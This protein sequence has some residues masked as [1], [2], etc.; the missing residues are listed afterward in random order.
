[1]EPHLAIPRRPLS[2]FAICG[3][4][5]GSQRL[6][7]ESA[8]PGSAPESG[9]TSLARTASPRGWDSQS[10]IASDL[11]QAARAAWASPWAVRA[12]P[13]QFS[14]CASPALHLSEAWENGMHTE[15]GH[16]TAVTPERGSATR[17]TIR[18]VMTIDETMQ[19]F[20]LR[21]PP[22]ADRMIPVPCA[23]RLP[24]KEQRKSVDKIFARDRDTSPSG[25][26]EERPR[27]P[28]IGLPIDVV[29]P[30]SWS[31]GPSSRHQSAPAG[32]AGSPG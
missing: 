10:K 17:V 27:T 28:N 26:E 18:R 12:S 2:A 4:A 1:M 8:L 31:P 6:S 19:R 21:Q 16:L 23:L 5:S 11:I 29:E 9:R 13:S 30:I 3:L 24:R 14:D 15:V 25:N 32:V 20:R 22:L 7:P